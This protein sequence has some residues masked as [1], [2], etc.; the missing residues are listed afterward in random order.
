MARSSKVLYVYKCA[1]CGH[2]D[3]QHL[4]DDSHDGEASTC[5]SCGAAVAL[6]WDGGVTLETPKTIADEAIER[7]RGRK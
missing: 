2:R 7:A 3:E 1:G 4:D 5:A 6:E